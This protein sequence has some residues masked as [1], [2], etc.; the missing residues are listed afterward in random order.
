MNPIVAT[1]SLFV[2]GV[3]LLVATFTEHGRIRISGF[4]GI[5]GKS[6]YAR[7]G[8]RITGVVT[9]VASVIV[10]VNLHP[11]G[12]SAS[13]ATDSGGILASTPF[14]TGGANSPS[15]TSAPPI[16]PS[17]LVGRTVVCSANVLPQPW[18]LE[19]ASGAD[20]KFYD[21]LNQGAFQGKNSVRVTYNLHGVVFGIGARRDESA[22]VLMQPNL[23]TW[24]VVDLAQYGTNGSNADQVV[25]I[26]LSDFIGLP[27]DP[28]H[29]PG[30]GHLDLAQPVTTVR[31]RFWNTRHFIVDIISIQ[32]CNSI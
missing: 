16:M 30:G 28:S 17:T 26:P 15:P 21:A 27:D 10:F 22:I 4:E 1:I 24:Y 32:P 3:V 5:V 18:H 23:P 19:A 11:L 25:D 9:I 14:S 13:N 8:F 7:W 20:E 2:L 6:P 29:T 12:K 31:A